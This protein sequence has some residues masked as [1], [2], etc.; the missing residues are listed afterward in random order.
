VQRDL[1]LHDADALATFL[2]AKLASLPPYTPLEAEPTA[3]I[4]AVLA[5]LYGIDSQPYLLFTR[6]SSD[7]PTHKG[8]ISFPGGS[9]DP[10]DVSLAETALREAKEEVGLE[11]AQVEI[12][13]ALHPVYVSV[14]NFVITP[15][16]G[17]LGE[18]LPQLH[19][20]PAEV[21]ELIQAP[22]AALADPTIYHAEVWHHLD[23][24]HLVHFFDFAPYVIWGATAMMLYS[25]LGLLP[26]DD[27][28]F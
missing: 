1:L 15:Q 28:S 18:G 21:A 27:V 25:L 8:Q 20:N 7:L 5:P 19:S 26:A 11:P 6:R 4:A 9:R 13:G 17:W 22:L 23:A 12:L 14:S 10:G 24:A 3:R 16:V 2:R